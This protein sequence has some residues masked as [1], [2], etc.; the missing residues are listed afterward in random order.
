MKVMYST[1][2]PLTF[3]YTDDELEIAIN[4]II[5]QI[6]DDTFSFDALCDALMMKAEKEN[7][8][9]KAPNTVYLSNNLDAKE[10]ERISI[11]LWKKIWAHE[12]CLNFHSNESNF[13]NYSFIKL[14]RN[15]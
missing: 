8:I 1:Y 4:G 13:N 7:K 15:E 5:E 3:K 2:K 10:Y 9:D 12:L 11:I 6:E 14:K